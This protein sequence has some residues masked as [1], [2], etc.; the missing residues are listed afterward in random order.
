LGQ[1]SLEII[2]DTDMAQS[3]H[4]IEVTS[5]DGKEIFFRSRLQPT[6]VYERQKNTVILWNDP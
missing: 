3:Q 1:G 6:N 4:Y 5:M 2:T